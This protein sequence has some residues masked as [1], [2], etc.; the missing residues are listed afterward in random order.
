MGAGAKQ[1]RSGMSMVGIE[2]FLQSDAGA[3]ADTMKQ[4]PD[5]NAEMMGVETDG[6]CLRLDHAKQLLLVKWLQQKHGAYR[7]RLSSQHRIVPPCHD[8][9]AHRGVA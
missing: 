2:T 4:V 5:M 1:R 8:D 9:D 6:G 7:R 3:L